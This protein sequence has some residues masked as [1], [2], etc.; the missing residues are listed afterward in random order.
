MA[1]ADFFP[2]LAPRAPQRTALDRRL[3]ALLSSGTIR[4]LDV[5]GDR[6]FD[7]KQTGSAAPVIYVRNGPRGEPH[8]ALEGIAGLDWWQPSPDGLLLAY[9]V[10][11]AAG[12]TELR[13]REI[14][15]ATDLPDR[16]SRAAQASPAWLPDRTGF[17]YTREPREPKTGPS[18]FFHRLGTDPVKDELFYAPASPLDRPKILLSADGRYLVLA[19]RHAAGDFEFWTPESGRSGTPWVRVAGFGKGRCLARLREHTL[20]VLTDDGAP[21]GRILSFDLAKRRERRLVPEGPFVIVDFAV[22]RHHVAVAAL[23]RSAARL[24]LHDLKGA[25]LRDIPL[26]GPGSVD[27]APGSGSENVIFLYQSF[28]EAPALYGYDPRN[29]QRSRIDAVP[30]PDAGTLRLEISSFKAS[31]ATAQ[32]IFLASGRWRKRDAATPTVLTT[33]AEAPRYKPEAVAWM[34]EGGLWAAIPRRE[35]SSVARRWL[36]EQEYTS[37]DRI[38]IP[39]EY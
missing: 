38:F 8:A 11:L 14:D 4:G 10:R 37:S 6:I 16:I 17:Y 29:S 18:V 34:Q 23:E 19:V 26:P 20:Y 35:D 9:G 21:H 3:E 28:F 7:L 36:I 22:T 32:P 1:Q 5:A 15:S 39:P 30:G 13:V 33:F 25:A 12:D 24:R 31:D 2:W 27:L